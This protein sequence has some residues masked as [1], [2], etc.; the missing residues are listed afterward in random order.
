MKLKIVQKCAIIKRGKILLI[1]RS[2]EARSYHGCW[3]L[4]GGNLKKGE[5]LDFALKREVKEETNLKIN[6]TVVFNAFLSEPNEIMIGFISKDSKGKVKT[7]KE[8]T[9]YKWINL[10]KTKKMKIQPVIKKLLSNLI[11]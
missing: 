10:K 1:K 11:K 9:D 2:K 6:K 4:P 8:H 3:D 7:S 5:K